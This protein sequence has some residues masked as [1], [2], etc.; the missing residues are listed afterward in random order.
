MKV[1]NTGIYKIYKRE[2]KNCAQSRFWDKKK[3]YYGFSGD[4][5]V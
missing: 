1:I 3:I 4:V 5:A 2:K